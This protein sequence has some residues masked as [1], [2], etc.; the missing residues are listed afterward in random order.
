M[1]FVVHIFVK[2]NVSVDVVILLHIVV[3]HL[4]GME[5]VLIQLQ[6][7][8]ISGDYVHIRFVK[9][10]THVTLEM[11][12]YVNIQRVGHVIVVVKVLLGIIQ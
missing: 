12:V 1:I 8:H 2:V 9:M 10:E 5:D 4:G 3:Q 7:M 6:I 11:L